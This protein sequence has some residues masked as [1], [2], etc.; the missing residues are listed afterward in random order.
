MDKNSIEESFLNDDPCFPKETRGLSIFVDALLDYQYYLIMNSYN[1][2]IHTCDVLCSSINH[3]I[4]EN[5]NWRELLD[6]HRKNPTYN[7]IL[8]NSFYHTMDN[9]ETLDIENNKIYHIEISL[10]KEALDILEKK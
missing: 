5:G 4:D 6:T 2:N 1:N 3:C 9:L 10:L 7:K 8:K